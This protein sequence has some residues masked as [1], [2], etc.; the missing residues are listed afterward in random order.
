MFSVEV[1]EFLVEVNG[2][3]PV[4]EGIDYVGE[5]PTLGEI[6]PPEFNLSEFDMDLQDVRDLLEDEGM[7]I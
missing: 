3:Y 1:Q 4:I 6:N 2:E 7:V 5:L